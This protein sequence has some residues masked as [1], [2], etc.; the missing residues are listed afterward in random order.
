MNRTAQELGLVDMA[1][2]QYLMPST[3]TVSDLL[4]A[5]HSTV[6]NGRTIRATKRFQFSH[7]NSK[8]G[9]SVTSSQVKH[10]LNFGELRLFS[11]TLALRARFRFLHKLSRFGSIEK[12][13]T[14]YRKNNRGP[15]C[16]QNTNFYAKDG[17]IATGS[18][19]VCHVPS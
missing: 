6:P 7:T 4:D 1:I 10:L 19:L 17:E 2:A 8:L 9:G 5:K 3:N 11:Q 14:V 18:R 13:C 15:T 16:R 12:Q